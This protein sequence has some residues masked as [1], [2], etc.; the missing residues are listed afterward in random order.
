MFFKKKE[1]VVLCTWLYMAPHVNF[2]DFALGVE[3][4][5]FNM[6]DTFGTAY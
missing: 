3:Q 6:H 2:V 1:T 4:A 5:F